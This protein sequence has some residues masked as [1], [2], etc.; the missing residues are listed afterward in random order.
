[1]VG[2]IA[3]F[4]LGFITY[5]Y[6]L[7]H[8]PNAKAWDFI[9]FYM[10]LFGAMICLAFSSA[11]HTLCCHSE[12][13]CANWNRCDYVGIVTLIVGSF[14]PMMYYGEE[15]K[16]SERFLLLMNLVVISNFFFDS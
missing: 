10:F 3:F 6:V 1:L 5:F 13:V 9:V 15:I 16:F 8:Q 11:F 2:T 4:L 7:A 14:F 12:K